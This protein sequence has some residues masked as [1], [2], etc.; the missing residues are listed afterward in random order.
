M[1]GCAGSTMRCGSED[2]FRKAA[3]S[4]DAFIRDM[5]GK[6]KRPGLNGISADEEGQGFSLY[7]RGSHKRARGDGMSCQTA[8]S[9]HSEKKSGR[10]LLR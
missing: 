8:L 6:Q 4:V 2:D 3:V 7:S 1:I 10:K 9:C 5:E